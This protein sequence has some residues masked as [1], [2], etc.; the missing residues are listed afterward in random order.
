MFP[1]YSVI[2]IYN[3]SEALPRLNELNYKFKPL[4]Y[5][6]NV[7]LTLASG[8]R[9]YGTHFVIFQDRV[10]PADSRTPA[11]SGGSALNA[12]SLSFTKVSKN[13]F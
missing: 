4:E 6:G 3:K 8:K 10:R 1:V 9:H 7:G 12:K 5:R 2:S 11:G 13:D